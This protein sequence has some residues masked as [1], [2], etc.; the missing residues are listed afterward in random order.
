MHEK[1]IFNSNIYIYIYMCV[2]VCVCVY[3]FVRVCG[4]CVCVFHG[5]TAP[6]GPGLPHY[7]GFTITLRHTTLGRIPLDAWSAHRRDL[8]LTTHSIH[9]RQNLHARGGI[10]TRN[11]S[12]RA[13][14]NPRLRPSGHWHRLDEKQTSFDS[15][16]FEPKIVQTVTCRC[17]GRLTFRNSAIFPSACVHE[18]RA[19]LRTQINYFLEQQRKLLLTNMQYVY[20]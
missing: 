7:R 6:I 15:P 8:H 10:R 17:S 19:I 3:L 1:C 18:F 12:K 16:G 9:K 11:A 4:V 13:A 2:C 5:S 14:A 20:C